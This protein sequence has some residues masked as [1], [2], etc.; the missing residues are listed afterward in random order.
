MNDEKKEKNFVSAVIY[1]H[2]GEKRISA[3]LDMVDHHLEDNFLK[4]EIICV[5]DDSTDE[6]AQKIKE[7]AAKSDTGGVISCLNMSFH[8]G[9][10]AG[11]DAGVDL[12]IG[13]F[14]YEFDS[15]LISYSPDLIRK[16]YDRCLEGFDIV[17]A[18][19]QNAGHKT[20]DVFYS[21]YNRYSG[22]QY[23]L[24]TESFRILSRRAINRVH[25]MSWTIPYRK[26]IY[27]NCGLATD[28][29]YYESTVHIPPAARKEKK[30]QMETAQD[31][32]VLYTDVAYRISTAFSVIMM[33]VTILAVIYTICIYVTG[34]PVAG[35]TTTMLFLSFGFFGMS[36]VLT[37]LIK[38]ASL[39]LKTV[40]NKQKYVVESIE[41]LK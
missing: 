16:I 28:A 32:L 24:R 18:C 23:K 17:S 38:Y 3:F 25:S 6:T 11:M 14:V 20:S 34:R 4:Y 36:L 40:F 30:L 31:A 39:I 2:N 15:M 35:W 21:L 8:Q 5:N 12:A 41:K 22:S 27:A 19:P 10:E 33:A 9:L 26:A 37:I 29:I 7:Y 13:D 1:M